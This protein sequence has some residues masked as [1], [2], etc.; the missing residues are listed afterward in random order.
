MI[1][2]KNKMIKTM[3]LSMGIA[4]LW[5]SS[6]LVIK[7]TAVVLLMMS[8]AS[9]TVMAEKGIQIYKSKR[10]SK[11]LHDF[12]HSPDLNKALETLEDSEQEINP[13]KK[14]AL[15]G[16]NAL[17]HHRHTEEHL[18]DS[19]D[20]NDWITSS[21]R[22]AIDDAREQFGSGLIILASIGSTA[23]FV[24]LFGTVCGIYQALLNI[25]SN[26]MSGIEQVAGPIGEAL[27]MTAFGL[28]VAIPAVLGYNALL[29]G[30]Q[31]ILGKLNRF[32]YDLRAFYVTG[33]ALKK[34]E[35]IK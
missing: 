20:L 1:I 28:I 22:N 27:I 30:N 19:L 2:I 12:W 25:D 14:L 32:A 35:S 21:L 15:E 13:F 31:F 4:D 11:L 33:T 24:G 8:I 29:R 34:P 9:W 6:G 18:H 7:L 5:V 10:Q 26:R 3:D 16:Q 17:R 23:P